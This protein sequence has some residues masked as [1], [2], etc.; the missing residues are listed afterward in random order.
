[1][2]LRAPITGLVMLLL[3]TA[4]TVSAGEGVRLFPLA[5]PDAEISGGEMAKVS[6]GSSFR[7]SVALHRSSPHF[8]YGKIK[9]LKKKLAADPAVAGALGAA[10]FKIAP[11]FSSLSAFHSAE[12]FVSAAHLRLPTGR[13]PP[14]I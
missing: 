11:L 13:A 14:I 6:T 9:Q 10:Q 2:T 12:T 1:M 4:L 7:Y 8:N 5:G 3:L